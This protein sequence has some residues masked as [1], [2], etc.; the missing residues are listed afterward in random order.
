MGLMLKQCIN[1]EFIHK[2]SAGL[3]IPFTISWELRN[4]FIFYIYFLKE[5]C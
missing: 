1:N 4:T 2:L 5:S 3:M